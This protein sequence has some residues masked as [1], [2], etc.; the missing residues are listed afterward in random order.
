MPQKQARTL[1]NAYVRVLLAIAQHMEAVSGMFLA[2]RPIK[3]VAT[4]MLKK[5]SFR[6]SAPSSSRENGCALA[7]AHRKEGTHCYNA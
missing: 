2:C 1:T 3:I 6:F 5:Y 7:D 4:A